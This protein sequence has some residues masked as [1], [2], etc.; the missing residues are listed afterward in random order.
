[1]T[2]EGS[3]KTVNVMTPGIGVLVCLFVCLEFFRHYMAELLPMRRKT[4]YNQ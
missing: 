1:M 3:T 4:L 2:E